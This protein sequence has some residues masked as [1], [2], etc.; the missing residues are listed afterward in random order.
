MELP[1][2]AVFGTFIILGRSNINQVIWIFFGFWII[3]YFHRVFIFPFMIRTK[4]KKMPLI[5]VLFAI[6]FNCINGFINGYW[7]GFLSPPYPVSWLYDPRFIIGVIFFISGFILNKISDQTL[8]K[9]R[10]IK[11]TGYLIPRGGLFNYISCPN[12]FG[13]II[14]W[15]GFAIMTWCL[16]GFSFA[17]WTAVNLIP[18]ALDHH[19]WYKQTFPDYPPNRKAVIPFLL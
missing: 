17:F 6:F 7:F 10:S 2:F 13:E 4:G 15:T 3:H 1:A 11:D 8:L 14:E 12:F 16:P 19:K 9:L 5:I 18:R